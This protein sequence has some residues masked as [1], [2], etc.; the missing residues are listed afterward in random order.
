FLNGPSGYAHNQQSLH[1]VDLNSCLLL[2]W[3]CVISS[4]A[5]CQGKHSLGRNIESTQSL[6]FFRALDNSR[7]T[8]TVHPAENPSSKG[9]KTQ[10]VDQSHISFFNGSNN[11][12]FEATR[13]FG[14][15]GNHHT[16]NNFLVFK[17]AFFS[18]MWSKQSISFFR[19][20]FLWFAL[21]IRRVIVKTLVIFL[22]ITTRFKHDIRRCC[23]LFTHAFGKTCCHHFFSVHTGINT[24]HIHKVSRPHWPS[25]TFH[26]LVNLLKVSTVTQQ[27]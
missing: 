17:F 16:C 10:T 11:V 5:F 27:H 15:H 13:H 21:F 8:F 2:P 12:F 25:P 24:N 23:K 19:N 26:N 20:Q 1:L 9:W 22:A 3:N 7:N 14:R 18:A 6:I 4:L